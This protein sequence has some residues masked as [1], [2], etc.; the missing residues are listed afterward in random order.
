MKRKKKVKAYAGFCWTIR[1]WP[2]L[3]PWSLCLMARG[4]CHV[5]VP[6]TF[7]PEPFSSRCHHLRV[8]VPT[9][10]ATGSFQRRKS[11]KQLAPAA[12]YTAA[13]GE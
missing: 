11:K 7:G 10:L 9:L 8:C 6:V 4:S 12:T 13:Q 1:R 5:S 2:G 3:E